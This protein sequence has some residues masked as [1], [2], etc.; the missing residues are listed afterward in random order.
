[1]YSDKA[2]GFSTGGSIHFDASPI[3]EGDESIGR[4]PGRFVVNA[5]HIYLGMLSGPSEN[6]TEDPPAGP[7]FAYPIQRAV[8]GNNMRLYLRDLIELV[9]KLVDDLYDNYSVISAEP[10]EPSAPNIDNKL[11]MD[12]YK[13]ELGVLRDNLSLKPAPE[14][15][16]EHAY[17]ELGNPD[18]CSFLSKTVKLK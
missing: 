3:K 11:W 14:G 5:Q 15:T 17:W 18:D 16:E 2:I 13:E 8:L 10:G 9:F 6:L 4:A 1:M 7:A 12:T